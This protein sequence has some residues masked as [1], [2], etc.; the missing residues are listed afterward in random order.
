MKNRD[1]LTKHLVENNGNEYYIDLYLSTW[2]S[3]P[4]NTV[5]INIY[6]KGKVCIF[7]K[8]NLVGSRWVS[9]SDLSENGYE[10]FITESIKSIEEVEKDCSHKEQ[11]LIDFQK[12]MGQ[13]FE[14]ASTDE[15][16]DKQSDREEEKRKNLLKE[17]H[18][19][20]TKYLK[21]LLATKLTS[22]AKSTLRAVDISL[23]N[24]GKIID[25]APENRITIDVFTKAYEALKANRSEMQRAE[26]MVSNELEY[27]LEEEIK[28][29]RATMPGQK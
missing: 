8:Y 5:E 19:T 11:I 20:S 3:T 1:I 21:N 25:E 10:K 6:K 22:E 15:I 16:I 14:K 7:T 9:R 23:Q 17:A 18:R 12:K 26:K 2:S 29:M 27:V 28:L 13:L 4:N 24:I